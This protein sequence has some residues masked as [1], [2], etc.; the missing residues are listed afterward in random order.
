MNANRPVCEFIGA[1][2]LAERR[3]C[4]TSSQEGLSPNFAFALAS[5]SALYL[6]NHTRI[7]LRLAINRIYNAFQ[8]LTFFFFSLDS[9]FPTVYEPTVFENYVHGTLRL[10][11]L[12][13][14]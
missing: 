11:I 4:S 12:F 5:A 6:F 9:Y 13:S 8:A 1:M 3:R 7:R 2:V 10:L 14:P